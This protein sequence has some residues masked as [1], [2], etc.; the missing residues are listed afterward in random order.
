VN[1]SIRER[2]LEDVTTLI[3]E[4]ED[5]LETGADATGDKLREAQDAARSRLRH[6]RERLTHFEHDVARDV[7]AKLGRADRYVHENPWMAVGTA[8]TIAFL[9][10]SLAHRR[11]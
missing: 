8:A 10:G 5:L 7:K 9:L 6:A 3:D 4:V 2:L 11:D 1:E